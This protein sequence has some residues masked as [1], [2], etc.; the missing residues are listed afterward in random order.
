MRLVRSVLGIGEGFRAVLGGEAGQLGAG[1]PELRVE[2]AA[3]G[4][5]DVAG[6]VVGHD[7]VIDQRVQRIFLAQVLEEVLLPSALEHPMGDLEG[8]EMW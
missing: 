8:G 6:G 4:I 1:V 7:A 2:G 3:A 5:G